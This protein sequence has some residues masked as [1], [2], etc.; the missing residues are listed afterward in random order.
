MSAYNTT[1]KGTVNA[2]KTTTKPSKWGA[3]GKLL[4][5]KKPMC[6]DGTFDMFDGES[7]DN[8]DPLGGL[9]GNTG[10]LGM[11]TSPLVLVVG[12]GNMLLSV[13]S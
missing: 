2:Y 11:L 3:L 7:F 12:G 13:M 5:G 1:K 4:G 6:G 9:S 8:F 10:L